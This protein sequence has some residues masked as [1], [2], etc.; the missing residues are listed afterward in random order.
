MSE[1]LSADDLLAAYGAGYFPMAESRDSDELYWFN[2]DKR[3]ILPINDF[4]VP[5]SLRKF[6]R[7]ENPFETRF[8]TAFEEVMRNCAEIPRSHEDN[9]WINDEMIARYSELNAMGHA[10]SVE[11]WRDGQLIGGLYGV[12]IGGAFCGESMFSYESQA[13]KVALVMLVER[14][15]AAGYQLLDTQFV[16]EHLQ[17]FG[18]IEITKKRYLALLDKA[19]TATPSP[20]RRF[21]T[22]SV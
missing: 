6:M 22:T 17:Q 14:L 4:R 16:N 11:S 21:S 3:G 5:R 20:S 19:L 13:S 9:T 18:V 7:R 15:R 8:N 1:A 12:S 2:P 10:H